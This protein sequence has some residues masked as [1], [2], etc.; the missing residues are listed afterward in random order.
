MVQLTK[1]FINN[2]NKDPD[3]VLRSLSV[4]EIVNIIQKANY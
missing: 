4:N 1:A 3:E 2:L